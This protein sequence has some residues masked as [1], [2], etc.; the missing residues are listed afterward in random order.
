MIN[1]EALV[2]ITAVLA[3]LA[4][5]FGLALFW[6]QSYGRK[7]SLSLLQSV[8]EAMP[9]GLAYFDAE[10]R[11]IM[12]NTQYNRELANLGLKPEV[13]RSYR[14]I[15]ETASRLNWGL[16][17]PTEQQ[18]RVEEI[19]RSRLDP[20]SDYDSMMLDGRFLRVQSVRTTEG[21][22]V[23]IL[24]D[25][26]G[27]KRQAEVLAQARDQSEAATRAK[28]LFLATMSHEIRTPLNGVLGMAQAMAHDELSAPQ[29]DRLDVI[30]TSGQALLAVL[31]DVLDI[32]KIEAGKL[33]I[34]AIPFD[35]DEVVGAARDA[36]ASVASQRNLTFELSVQDAAH[37]AY[38]GDPTRLRQILINL[39]SNALKFTQKG[40]VT[41]EVAASD[42]DHLVFKVSDTGIG[43]TPEQMG[44]LFEKFAQ[45]D[46]S[47]TRK[48]G[49]SGLGLA[50][51]QKLATLMGGVLEVDSVLDQ[52]SSFSLVLPL[53]RAMAPLES[54]PVVQ[55]E[56]DP[57]TTLRILA[58]ED[59]AVNRLVLKTLLAHVGIE[60]VMVENGVQAVEAWARADW[61]IILMDVQMP[62]M[63][64]LTATREIRARESIQHR[65]RTP[66]IALTANAMAHQVQDYAD[67][68]MDG[69]VAKPIEIAK[70]FAAIETALA[71]PQVEEDDLDAPAHDPQ[72]ILSV[73]GA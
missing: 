39:I 16:L 32:S 42:T 34:E 30:Q 50:I 28:S 59:N 47:T 57:N 10:D 55:G 60:P 38:I 61:D 20:S 11:F 29:R 26:T 43:M 4:M 63:D 24:S 51:C 1:Q 14:Q 31:N 3:A 69:F 13:G 41:V 64:G 56:L 8:I 44:R 23:T 62:E 6:M 48:Y 53:K 67:V 49:G 9:Q 66:I 15:I 33:E 2:V 21:G 17:S 52:G 72:R 22:I 12:G 35:L 27:L 7:R 65:P 25:I 73:Q 54:S 18:E 45:A 36:F 71:D 5:L 40:S 58:A 70:L 19:M 68:G 37:G 46:A